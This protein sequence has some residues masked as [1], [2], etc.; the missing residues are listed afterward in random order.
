MILFIRLLLVGSA[1]AFNFY[2]VTCKGF[3]RF[4][5]LILAISLSYGYRHRFSGHLDRPLKNML[6]FRLYPILVTDK[7]GRDLGNG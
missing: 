6:R 1:L 7:K 5:L 2:F 3:Y 4:G